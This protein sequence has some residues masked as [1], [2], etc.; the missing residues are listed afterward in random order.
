[1]GGELIMIANNDGN[2]YIRHALPMVK[3]NTMLIVKFYEIY[4]G[5]RKSC[6]IVQT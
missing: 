6:I 4:I 3:N 1:M 2:Y 5:V